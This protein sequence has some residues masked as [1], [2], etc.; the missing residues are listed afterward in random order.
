MNRVASLCEGWTEIWRKAFITS[1][2]ITICGIRNRSKIPTKS[3]R[4]TGPGSNVSFSE[5]SFPMCAD[6]SYT[7]R[8]L[9]VITGWCGR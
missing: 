1:V 4:I 6:P 9:W 3:G 2:I 8:S 7:I 5:F